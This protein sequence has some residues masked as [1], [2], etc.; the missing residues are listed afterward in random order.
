MTMSDKIEIVITVTVKEPG[1][2]YGKDKIE[3]EAEAVYTIP[4]NSNILPYPEVQTLI[5]AA[6]DEY[7]AE[8]AEAAKLEAEEESEK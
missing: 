2:H 5:S 6:Y 8:K 3:G 4:A 1:Y 7:K